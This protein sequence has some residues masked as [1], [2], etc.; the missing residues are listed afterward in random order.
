MKSIISWIGGKRALVPEILP[1][2]PSNFKK[3]V[4]VFGGGASV[5]FAIKP[6]D[7]FEVY[8]DF[9]NNL[10]N[11]FQVIRDKP[12]E[13]L[14]E[15]GMFPLNSREEFNALKNLI[16]GTYDF[17]ES[18]DSELEIAEKNLSVPDY[19]EIVELLLKK[20]K[21]LDVRRAATYYKVVQLSYG[22]NC[23]SYGMKS[24]DIMRIQYTLFKASKRLKR[25]VIEN[26]DFERLISIYDSEY[27]FFYC[28]PPYFKTERSYKA[29][30]FEKDHIR[31]KKV[32]S[33]IKGKFLLSY[34]D[35]PFIR[36]LYRDYYIV[37]LTRLNNLKQSKD[38][39]SE[40][41]E[42][43]IANYDITNKRLAHEQVQLF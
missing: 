39:G 22:S 23:R 18:L 16:D 33:N 34:N 21:R 19:E 42:L 17:N 27:T 26:L 1:R 28:D 25:T 9:Q 37:P 4:E 2:F 7:T 30:F 43:L 31:L 32:L 3:Y 10:T 5:L 41:P 29:D 6:T 24:C 8:N 15:L 40:F 35:C 20:A 13:L 38:P 36:E 12:L 14:H 11:L